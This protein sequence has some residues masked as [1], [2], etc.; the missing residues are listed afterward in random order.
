MTG[1]R[2]GYGYGGRRRL[3]G[4]CPPRRQQQSPCWPW[5]GAAAARPPGRFCSRRRHCQHHHCE[6]QEQE[7]QLLLPAACHRHCQHP[8]P[9]PCVKYNDPPHAA[10]TA[11]SAAP[12]SIPSSAPW[13]TGSRRPAAAATT[14]WVLRFASVLWYMVVTRVCM[15]DL[16]D[17]L[18]NPT[19]R[20]TSN[21]PSRGRARAAS[22]QRPPHHP[23]QQQ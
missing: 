3:P 6:A 19:P 5:W 7:Q 23:H 13:P 21:V 10:P 15:N 16:P 17:L 11:G 8:P 18:T 1:G 2:G 4:I 9:P 22:P 12:A 14:R 20:H